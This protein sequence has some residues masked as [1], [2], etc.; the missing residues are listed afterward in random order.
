LNARYEVARSV[1]IADIDES[2][3]RPSIRLNEFVKPTIA[4]AVKKIAKEGLSMNRV[5]M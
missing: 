5:L 2:P 1:M 4:K 3:L